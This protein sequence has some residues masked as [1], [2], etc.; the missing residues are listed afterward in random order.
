MALEAK[1]KAYAHKGNLQ[2]A[3][4]IRTSVDAF[5]S[6]VGGPLELGKVTARGRQCL[7]ERIPSDEFSAPLRRQAFLVSEKNVPPK[8]VMI[9][10]AFLEA[11][12]FREGDFVRINLSGDGQADAQTIVLKDI[13]NDV[14][15]E[16]V[17]AW[18]WIVKDKLGRYIDLFFRLFHLSPRSVAVHATRNPTSRPVYPTAPI[19]AVHTDLHLCIQHRLGTYSLAWFLSVPLAAAYVPLSQLFPSTHNMTTLLGS[20]T[21][22]QR[23]TSN[24]PAR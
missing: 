10:K 23:L 11:T 13:A 2:G 17:D 19:H 4:L 3:A 5:R 7:V 22:P 12:G 16:L 18:K 6:L 14:M 15:P 20:T 9:T 8:T 21:R 24:S 1:V